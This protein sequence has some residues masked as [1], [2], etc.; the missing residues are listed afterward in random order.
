M[1][2]RPAT[3][4]AFALLTSLSSAASDGSVP[5]TAYADLSWRLAGPLRGGWATAASGVPGEPHTFYFGAAD[6]G[7]WKTTDAGR[8]WQP[9]FQNESVAAIGALVVAPSNPKILYAGT[10]QVTTRW[11]VTS[12]DGVYRSMDGGATW[13][14]R[15]L[16]ESE[17]IGRIWVDPRDPDLV[18]VAALGHLHGPNPERGVFRTS[19]GGSSWT[20]VL[21]VDAD[22]GAVDLAADPTTPD[23][24]FAATWQARRFPWQAYFTPMIGPGSGIW[25]SSDAG[26]TWTRLS[27]HGLPT[28]VM[29]RIGLAVAPG[30][31]A[32]RVY[33]T[34]AAEAESGLYRSDDGGLKWERVNPDGSIS[35]DYF[36]ALAVDPRN[37]DTIHVM[38]RS[39]RTSLDGGKTLRYTRGSPGGDDYHFLWID[40]DHPERRIAAS[41]QGAV[42]TLN[43]GASWSSWYNQ[44]TGQFYRLATDDRFPY[45]IYSGQQDS[46]TVALASRSDYGQ[47]TF[48][49]WHPV[50]GD[51]RDHDIPFPGDPDIVYGSGL[52]GRL[53]RWD[54][55]TGQVRVLS[56]WPE[57]SYGRR[58]T[59]LR[60]RS[61]WLAPLAISPHAP[62]ATYMAAQVLLR[63]L[64]GGESWKEISPDLTGAVEGAP[65]CAGDVPVDRAT[66]CGYGVIFSIG[67]SPLSAEVIWLGTD[68][69]RIHVSR[70]G[71]TTWKNVTPPGLGDW[72]KVAAIDASTSDP[73][74][75]YAAVD[76]HRLDDWRPYA[77][78]THDFGSS[79]RAAS[80]GLPDGGYVNVVRQD[81]V[82]PG[83]LYAGTSR[84]AFVSFDDGA[85]WQSL[86]LD[87]PTTGINDLTVHGHDLIA[88]TQ[89]R[90][91]WVLDD[92]SPLRHLSPEV[93]AADAA[94][95]PPAPA[96]RLSPNQNRDTPLPVDEPR[97]ENPPAGAVIDYLLARA[98]QGPVTLEIADDQGAIVRSFESD[99]VGARPPADVYFPDDWLQPPEPLLA[100]VGHN[101]F[102]WN[103]RLPRPRA[104]DYE[105][106]IAAVPGADTPALP[107]GLFVLPGK[108]EVRLTVEG[109]TWKQPLTIAS[110]PRV[111]VPPAVLAS[112]MTFYRDVTRALESATDARAE[113]EGLIERLKALGKDSQALREAAESLAKTLGRFLSGSSEDDI[114]KPGSALGGLATDLES[115]DAAPSGP[116]REYGAI[117]FRRLEAAL[118][119]WKTAR[120]NEVREIDRRARE[121]GMPLFVP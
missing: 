34:I 59:G 31:R 15:G 108:Y 67:L 65:D 120:E 115:A 109:M 35:S 57:S 99:R 68:N 41:D 95:L 21:F 58:P 80:T 106:S 52:G 92:V 97:A 72:S 20:R 12:G 84:G 37:A 50:G 26:K 117:Q 75:A 55:R 62:H 4:I 45:W 76:R 63:S 91:I 17:H 116:Q 86:Q 2:R 66:A 33:A 89:G 54:A 14:H 19:D 77:Y 51:E 90:A 32:Q 74:T 98:P 16:Q 60:Y 13:Q 119:R 11:D 78:V 114:A 82:R 46:G 1:L 100:K 6:G 118:A 39:I 61:T 49:D 71:G 5:P 94:L 64:D 107:Q 44:P 29:G 96:W 28:S 101:R 10:G 104:S 79:W 93:L 56:P 102:V 7:V 69:G 88:A 121:A 8:T 83:L 81:P 18:L 85:R 43:D 27:G 3:S 38:G 73:A 25:R 53:T 24:L 70:D 42:V 111:P 112:Q 30:S 103:L 87:L 113:I 23:V 48:R 36:A 110:D 40:P 47:L 9:S 22:T 105:Y